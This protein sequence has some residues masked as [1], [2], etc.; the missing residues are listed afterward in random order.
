MSQIFFEAFVCS[1]VSTNLLIGSRKKSLTHIKVLLGLHWIALCYFCI[2]R[3]VVLRYEMF[4]KLLRSSATEFKVFC[5]LL[6]DL[7][8]EIVGVYRKTK[9]QTHAYYQSFKSRLIL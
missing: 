4:V 5:R 9:S 2:D 8:K 1:L 7:R 3:W 6:L